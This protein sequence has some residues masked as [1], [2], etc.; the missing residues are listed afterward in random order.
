[1]N[2]GTAGRVLV[3]LAV[4][5]LACAPVAWASAAPAG[6]YR[7]LSPVDHFD[8]SPPLRDIKPLR[9]V[10]GERTEREVRE[11]MEGEDLN[12]PLGPQ[13]VD[14]AVQDWIGSGEIPAPSVSF[15]GHEQHLQR[16]AARP[17]RRRRTEPLRGDEQS[18]VPG[19]RQELA[20]RSTARRSTTRCGPVSA[21]PARPRTRATRSCSTTRSRTAGCSAS[22]PRPVRPTT[23]ASPS[24]QTADPTG[25]Y[26]R[27]AFTTGSNFPDYPKYG[28]WSDALYISTREFAG[29]STFAGVGAYAIN[30]TDLITGNPAP[31]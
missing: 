19:L 5:T 26:Y 14:T 6:I 12:K 21:A 20:P 15:D 22:S 30:R 9:P 24:R 17:G 23:I 2:S 8:I 25:A 10:G 29:G 31:R 1:M 4:L 16:L 13:D 27:W 3:L 28:W 11:G 7:G 18:V